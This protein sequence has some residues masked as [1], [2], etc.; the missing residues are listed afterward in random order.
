MALPKILKDFNLF[1]DGNNWQG[2]INTISL[3]EMTRRMVEYEAAAWTVR[4]K[5]TWATSS[6]K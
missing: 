6:W 2:Q 5:S 3:P 4:S 1:G